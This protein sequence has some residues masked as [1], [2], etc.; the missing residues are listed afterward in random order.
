MTNNAIEKRVPDLDPALYKQ[1]PVWFRGA[2]A[3]RLLR[4]L[5]PKPL[6]RALPR[7][8]RMPLLPPGVMLPSG[9]ILGDPFPAGLTL[10]YGVW[11]P[12]GWL[13]GDPLPPGF[14]IDT[15]TFFPPGWLPG[16]PLPPGLTLPPGVTLPP[17]WRPGDLL[18]PGFNIDTSVF[19]PPG[20]KPGDPLPDGTIP[21]PTIPPIDGIIPP[22]YI[23][24][25]QPGPPHR[26]T[27]PTAPSIVWA[28]Y[29]DFFD[30]THY[31]K[32]WPPHWQA[33]NL[34]WAVYADGNHPQW[35]PIGTW[36]IGF[37]PSIIRI[38]LGDYNDDWQFKLVNTNDDVI[39]TSAYP[40]V[41]GTEVAVDTGPDYD[42]AYIEAYK[43]GDGYFALYWTNIW[44]YAHY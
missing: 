32:A 5:T 31:A 27:G 28:W 37:R 20:W 1:N 34:Q 40:Y 17:G 19:F 23:P 36:Y 18:P 33:Y 43:P 9:W 39:A 26:P 16:D 13:P 7:V 41:T 15:S 29:Y 25:W 3:Y 35:V 8:L 12:T 14:I 42:I 2:V 10:P 38:F 22:L 21:D 30:D 24:S 6:T 44:Y 4:L 11:F